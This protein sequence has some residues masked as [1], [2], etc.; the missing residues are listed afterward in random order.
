VVGLTIC[1]ASISRTRLVSL[2]RYTVKTAT[3]S[4]DV[5]RIFENTDG[6]LSP[7]VVRSHMGRSLHVFGSHFAVNSFK[8]AAKES[9]SSFVVSQLH[10]RRA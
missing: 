4:S 3:I 6:Q 5:G 10:I 7:A 1:I 8:S 2:W 9:T